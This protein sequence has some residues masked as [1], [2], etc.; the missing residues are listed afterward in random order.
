MPKPG[1]FFVTA[2]GGW[3][4]EVIRTVTKSSVN[5]AG[6][7]LGN[8][9]ILEAEPHGAVINKLNNRYPHATWSFYDLT[10]ETRAKIV[11]IS[12]T[13]VG[14]PYNYF[15]I[16]VLG[17]VNAYGWGAPSWVIKQLQ[18]PSSMVC[19]QMVDYIYLMAGV[20]L[21]KDGRVPAL[22]TP[23]D[24]LKLIEAGCYAAT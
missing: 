20:H 13:L 1:D 6:L 15:D 11:R 21:F 22:V 10:D 14:T 16:G 3:M 4:G 19:S 2:T 18:D 23:G 5:H 12:R 24:L 8:N 17:L 9:L 7:Y